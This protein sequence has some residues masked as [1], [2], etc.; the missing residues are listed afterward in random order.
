MSNKQEEIEDFYF[1]A[2]EEVLERLENEHNIVNPTDEE[3]KTKLEEMVDEFGFTDD[4]ITGI[5]ET[6][7][8]VTEQKN[9][10]KFG[11]ALQAALNKK[12]KK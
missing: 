4:E 7:K 5:I 11:N 10:S 6:T 2:A 12:N 1:G 8:I 3:I 9:A